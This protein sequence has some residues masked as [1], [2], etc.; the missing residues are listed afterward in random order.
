MTFGWSESIVLVEEMWQR[1]D[2]EINKVMDPASDEG[3]KQDAASRAG[4]FAEIIWMFMQPVM[5]TVKD[6]KKE[7]MLRHK[8]RQAGEVR[9][10]PGMAHARWKTITDGAGWYPSGAG[11]TTDPRDATRLPTDAEAMKTF[12]NMARNLFENAEVTEQGVVTDPPAHGITIPPNNWP[13]IKEA[14]KHGFTV[15][16]LAETFQ[17]TPDQ[18]RLVFAQL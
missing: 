13:T 14:S 9:V 7:G 10:T 5:P 2:A 17:T 16:Q 3:T 1:L 18:I 12:T 8:A 6:V 4:A 11:H 15:E